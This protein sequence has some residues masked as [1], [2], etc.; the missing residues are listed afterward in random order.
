MSES[1]V[2]WKKF[3]NRES[4][5][6]A[7]IR[8]QL[9]K[10]D[11]IDLNY[12]YNQFVEMVKQDEDCPVFG[13]SYNSKMVQTGRNLKKIGFVQF[14]YM[15]GSINLPAGITCDGAQECYSYAKKDRNSSN[16]TG[17]VLVKNLV[18]SDQD[19]RNYGGWC[20]ASEE[21]NQYADAYVHRHNNLTVLIQLKSV[22]EIAY[23]LYKT[24]RTNRLKVVRIHS[25]GDFRT[26]EYYLAWILCA[27]LMEDVT[28]FGYT[29][30]LPYLSKKFRTMWTKNIRIQFSFGSIF[31][32]DLPY[33]SD[34]NPVI[35]TCFVE[36][37]PKQYKYDKVCLDH[38]DTRDFQYIMDSKTF[39]LPLH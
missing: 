17:T 9:S 7:R 33:D 2:V 18:Y 16:K 30:I 26:I 24:I 21:E 6:K 5:G 3:T 15:V 35:P 12:E 31:D 19:G 32:N 28:F 22:A 20:Y 1:N 29:K 39:V 36:L 38:E 11:K 8:K 13:V 27:R 14:I 25:S 10:M 23:S 4:L 34:G 37:K